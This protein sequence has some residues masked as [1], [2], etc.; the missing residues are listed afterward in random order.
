M[1]Q[2]GYDKKI[3]NNIT[4][5]GSSKMQHSYLSIEKFHQYVHS[6]TL[7]PSSSELKAKWD[8]LQPFFV[9]LWQDF[10]KK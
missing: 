8:L 6:S 3:F 1:I 4:V 7:E 10:N 5:V 9:V 2:L